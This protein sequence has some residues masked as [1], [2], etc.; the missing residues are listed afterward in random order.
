MLIAAKYTN[1]RTQIRAERLFTNAHLSPL[2]RDISPLVPSILNP[3][4]TTCSRRTHCFARFA[5]DELLTILDSLALVR[6]GRSEITDFRGS[7]AEQL[8]I[9]AAKE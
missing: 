8:A 9:G 6:L 3:Y 4:R 5:L 7:F 1:S 2:P